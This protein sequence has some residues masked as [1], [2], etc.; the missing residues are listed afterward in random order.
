MSDK[1][2]DVTLWRAVLLQALQDGSLPEQVR[3]SVS[4]ER[5]RALA[6]I[7]TSIGVTAED[8]DDVC[9]MAG[10]DPQLFR[11]QAQSFIKSGKRFLLRNDVWKQT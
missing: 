5:A 6:F 11:E 2:N 1:N 3:G 7:C 9:D 10:V 4:I 8:F